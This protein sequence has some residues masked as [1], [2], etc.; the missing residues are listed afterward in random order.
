MYTSEFQPYFSNNYMQN[1][2]PNP[3]GSNNSK[4]LN[5]VSG[6]GDQNDTHITSKL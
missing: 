3:I 6:F 2:Q 5:C 4:Q 1:T